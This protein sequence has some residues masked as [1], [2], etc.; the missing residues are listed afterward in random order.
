LL[1]LRQLPIDVWPGEFRPLHRGVKLVEGFDDWF[2]RSREAVGHL[3]PEICEQWLYRHWRG[4][5]LCFIPL[6]GL[7]WTLERW[8][9]RQFLDTVGTWNTGRALDPEAD[10]RAMTETRLGK[11]QRTQ[12]AVALDAGEWDYAPI[13][14]SMPVGYVDLHGLD[15]AQ[16][17]LLVEG[18]QRR[19]YLNALMHR[20][21]ELG[22]QRVFVLRSE[23]L[24]RLAGYTPPAGY[25][26]DTV[27]D[28]VRAAIRDET[29]TP[30]AAKARANRPYQPKLEALRRAAMERAARKVRE[31]EEAANPPI[32]PAPPKPASPKLEAL[33]QAALAR[34]A[35]QSGK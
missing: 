15:C 31:A 12:T 18:H 2:A 5:P 4:T 24:E 19:R 16:T 25:P 1:D 30:E 14:L 28:K 13:V 11:K 9:P 26:G 17:Y 10:F 29:E 23:P 7:S 27:L 33:R 8:S 3:H 34:K 32:P 35:A 21:V 20:G 6:E 22:P